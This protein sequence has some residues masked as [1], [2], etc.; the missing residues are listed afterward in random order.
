MHLHSF[1]ALPHAIAMYGRPQ[2]KVNVSS[3]LYDRST[4]VLWY[5]SMHTNIAMQF[6]E[7]MFNIVIVKTC[8]YS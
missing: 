4:I 6:Y 8:T 3:S 5:K 7:T 2:K 1:S